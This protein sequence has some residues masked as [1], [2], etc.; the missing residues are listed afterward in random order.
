[1][2]KIYLLPFFQKRNEMKSKKLQTQKKVALGASDV[3]FEG[4]DL[5]ILGFLSP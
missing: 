3:I 1:M 4:R 2:W 5:N